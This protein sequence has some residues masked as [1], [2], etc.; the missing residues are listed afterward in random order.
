ME[1]YVS[2][3]I[4]RRVAVASAMFT[5]RARAESAEALRKQSVDRGSEGQSRSSDR[6]PEHGVWRLDD[7]KMR[8]CHFITPAPSR[9]HQALLLGDSKMR[10]QSRIAAFSSIRSACAKQGVLKTERR[11]ALMIQ[12]HLTNRM[13]LKK[14]DSTVLW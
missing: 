1:H 10:C 14:Q 9:K 3:V 2:G 11:G 13:R 4:R 7:S 8:H 5:Q 6:G 12:V